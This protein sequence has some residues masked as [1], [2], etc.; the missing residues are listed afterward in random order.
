MLEEIIGLYENGCVF[1]RAMVE[2][3]KK[4]LLCSFTPGD[5]SRL[6]AALI[7]LIEAKNAKLCDVIDELVL[8][9]LLY[10]NFDLDVLI[11]TY[12]ADGNWL[13]PSAL[14]GGGGRTKKLLYDRLKKDSDHSLVGLAWIGDDEIVESFIKWKNHPPK[15]QSELFIPA[16]SYSHVA[17]WELTP[18]NKKRLLFSDTCY[19][20]LPIAQ[21]DSEFDQVLATSVIEHCMYCQRKRF[22][23]I[24][25]DTSFLE[26]FFGIKIPFPKITIP[27]CDLCSVFNHGMYSTIL[28]GEQ[29][30]FIFE[31]LTKSKM[32]SDFSEVDGD[33]GKLAFGVNRKTR[34]PFYA[35]EWNQN[36]SAQIGGFP[37]WIQDAEFPCCPRCSRTMLFFLQVDGD[38]FPDIC[39]GMFY[40]FICDLCPYQICV[41]KQFS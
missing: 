18:D 28:D 2:S 32:P 23:I 40:V 30:E 19:G 29:A 39:Y 4:E 36:D 37:T 17:G 38:L 5:F 8:D 26:Q 24:N 9:L 22:E 31:E 3:R 16:Y 25:V 14:R 6:E 41:L 12:L 20:L 1:D 7:A 10:S 15:W 13:P 35:A 21:S 11:S 34:D 27:F 33:G